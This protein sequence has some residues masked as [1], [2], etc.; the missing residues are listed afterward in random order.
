MSE[1]VACP[2]CQRKLN[3][4]DELLGQTVRCPACGE[5]FTAE[6]PR[7]A[8][9]PA[10]PPAAYAETPEGP[11]RDRDD[12]Y[13]RRR[14]PDDDYDDRGRRGP[15]RGYRDRDF[16]RAPREHRGPK[17]QMLGVLSLCLCFIPLVGLILGGMAVSMAN[18]DLPEM[19]RGRIDESGRAATEAGRTC[20]IVGMILNG[21]LTFC[22]CGVLRAL[23]EGLR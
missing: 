6:P 8:P 7:P 22:G 18:S 14:P 15:R 3:V 12:D 13:G 21:I 2:H 1:I 4:R 19:N 23:L 5:M 17:V 10:A 11:G 16:Y 20:A 9:R